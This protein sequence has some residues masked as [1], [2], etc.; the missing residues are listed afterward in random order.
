LSNVRV[1][2][3]GLL[4]FVLGLSSV[5]TGLAFVIIITRSLSPDE[6]GV[7]VLIGTMVAYF[8]ASEKIVSFWTLRQIARDEDVASSS[9]AASVLLS[10]AAVPL[11]VALSYS[12]SA[13]ENI[14]FGLVVLGA[15]MIPVHFVSETLSSVNTG[16]QPHMTSWSHLF[17]KIFRIPAALLFVYFLD[18]GVEG[19]VLTLT[20][21][22]GSKVILQL[23]LARRKIHRK[24][25]LKA[26][27]R[28]FRL[29]WIPLYTEAAQPIIALDIVLYSLITNS[30]IGLAYYSAALQ[31]GVLV[32]YAALIPMGLYPKILSRGRTEDVKENFALMMYFSIPL[33][34][35]SVIFAK[36]AVF[37]LNPEYEI[38]SVLVP[39][40]AFKTFFFVLYEFADQVLRGI[41]NVDRSP[42]PSFSQL[43]QSR[44]FYLPTIRLVQSVSYIGIFV[45]VIHLLNG[46]GLGEIELVTYWALVS[47]TVEIPASIFLLAKLRQSIRFPFS[48]GRIAR[49]AGATVL[50]SAV[51]ALTSGFV[52][53]YDDS[54]HRFL[55]GLLLQALLCIG[56]YLSV[57]YLIDPKTRELSRKVLAEILSR[58]R[59]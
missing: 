35:M 39:I 11:Y 10:A 36:P 45:I 3:S 59:A 53:T 21:A 7:W 30:V 43:V 12:L 18:L 22:F 20:A 58:S 29:L 46:Q 8:L 42:S 13:S 49:Y 50:S 54:L 33:L 37:A 52:I 26:I 55:P 14:S 1:T 9:I 24:I 31:I 16:F 48:L 4:A 17:F 56:A 34:G 28:W 15:I 27:K 40:L 44:L 57:T 2:Y 47:L 25:S 23:F 38:A 41:E 19:A 6:Y 51:Y 32:R 5:V